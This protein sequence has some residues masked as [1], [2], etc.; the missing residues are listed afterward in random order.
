MEFADPKRLDEIAAPLDAVMTQH[1]FEQYDGNHNG[2]SVERFFRYNGHRV[3]YNLHVNHDSKGKRTMAFPVS[4]LAVE[5]V[6]LTGENQEKLYGKE[7]KS[8]R[9][10]VAVAKGMASE[11]SEKIAELV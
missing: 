4:A 1:E 2:S 11:M 10:A 3:R 8:S 9:D 7:I 5:V 6:L